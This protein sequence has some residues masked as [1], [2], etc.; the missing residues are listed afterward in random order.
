MKAFDLLSINP[1]LTDRVRLSLMAVLSASREPLDFN[2][3]MTNLDLT[4]GNLSSHLRK[5]EEAGFISVTK[6]FVDRKPRTSYQCTKEG[7]KE[8]SDYLKKMEG[9]LHSLSLSAAAKK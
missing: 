5:L 3:L 6:E 9:L 8:L 4:K 1:L 2:H 7:R